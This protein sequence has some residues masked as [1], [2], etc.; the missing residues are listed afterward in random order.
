MKRWHVKWGTQSPLW[1]SY[2]RLKTIA[3]QHF[4]DWTG[5]SRWCILRRSWIAGQKN[6]FWNVHS[7]RDDV[8]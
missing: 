4:T 2:Q 7:S 8:L 5:E 3:F 6:I 1:Q